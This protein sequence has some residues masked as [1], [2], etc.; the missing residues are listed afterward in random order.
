MRIGWDTAGGVG[1]ARVWLNTE[2]QYFGG[3]GLGRGLENP[4]WNGAPRTK[5]AIASSTSHPKDW[6]KHEESLEGNHAMPNT[7]VILV[8][9]LKSSN[10]PKNVSKIT[11]W[12]QPTEWGLHW[13]STNFPA[14]VKVYESYY[15]RARSTAWCIQQ[16]GKAKF[17]A[18]VSETHSVCINFT[19]RFRLLQWYFLKVLSVFKNYTFFEN[20]F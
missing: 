13:F 10:C 18:R 7:V 8:Y 4:G 9:I 16:S 2:R 17:L 12:N 3:L 11:L 19:S 15:N 20:S 1:G 5:Y 6:L 14:F